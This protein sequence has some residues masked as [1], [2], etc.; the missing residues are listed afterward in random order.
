M[1]SATLNVAEEK[2]TPAEIDQAREYLEHTR[3]HVI[4]A[5]KG[6]TEAQWKFK[7]SAD[8][9]S[10]EEIVEHMV[11]VQERVLGPI[12]QKLAE[13]PIATNNDS[14]E[15]DA[16][17]MYQIADRMTKRKGP[18]FI[19]PT[20]RVQYAESMDRLLS[21]Y[22]RLNEVLETATGLRRHIIEAAP[23]K[24][25]TQGKYQVMDGYEWVLTAGAHTDRHTRQILEVKADPRFPLN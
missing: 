21:N 22:Q 4:G 3:K 20:G 18:D 2:L 14:Q 23:L 24:A 19:M 7:P 1:E 13:S 6:L 5:T 16:I 25:I 12:L 9:W 11:M 10:I 17:V 8:A 15:V